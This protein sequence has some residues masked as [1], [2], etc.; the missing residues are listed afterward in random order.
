MHLATTLSTPVIFQRP[1]AQIDATKYPSRG[2]IEGE[3][4][5]KTVSLLYVQI[6][7]VYDVP[8]WGLEHSRQEAGWREYVDTG[9]VNSV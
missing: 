9:Q 7:S 1:A 5:F 2:S 4:I 3:H 8:C 6:C